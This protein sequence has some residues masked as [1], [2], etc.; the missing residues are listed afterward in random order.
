MTDFSY[1]RYIL[2]CVVLYNK[3]EL[4]VKRNITINPPYK[5]E[6]NE[7]QKTTYGLYQYRI[8]SIHIWI[9]SIQDYTNNE[10]VKTS[11][12][13]HISAD[14][15]IQPLQYYYI[16]Y[17]TKTLSTYFNSTT[18]HHITLPQ[19]ERTTANNIFIPERPQ[20]IKCRTRYHR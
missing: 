5:H 7:Y 1:L 8:I 15:K 2:A 18:Y 3:K 12:I 10:R 19:D 4:S 14:E 20:P 11:T 13:Y 9:I 17:R 16:P 6:C